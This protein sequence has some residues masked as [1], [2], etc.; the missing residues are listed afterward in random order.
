[1]FVCFFLSL[2][3]VPILFDSLSY[4]FRSWSS[5]LLTLFLIPELSSF[6]KDRVLVEGT[7]KLEELL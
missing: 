5:G 3:V 2:F 6:L 7:C 4:L 1:M